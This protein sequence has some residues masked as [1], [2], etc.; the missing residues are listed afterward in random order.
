MGLG[1]EGDEDE[2]HM[3]IIGENLDSESESASAE[4]D[5]DMSELRN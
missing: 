5:S 4:E 1:A 3:T 2:S